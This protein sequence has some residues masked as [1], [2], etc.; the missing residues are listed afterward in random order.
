MSSFSDKIRELN[1]KI[2]TKNILLERYEKQLLEL[3]NELA[4]KTNSNSQEKI[5][6][7]EGKLKNLQIQLQSCQTEKDDCS[8]TLG[9]KIEE[10]KNSN[11]SVEE[12]SKQI[13]EL[14]LGNKTELDKSCRSLT[15]AWINCGKLQEKLRSEER[16]VGKECRTKRGR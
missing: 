8:L 9:T 11:L 14:A 5:N 1:K 15:N 10:I 6:D 4:T 2:E 16:R 13:I 7:L 12:K 3:S